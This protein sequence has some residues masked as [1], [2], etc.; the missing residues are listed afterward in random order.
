MRTASRFITIV[1]FVILKWLIPIVLDALFKLEIV[2]LAIKVLHLHKT[3][4]NR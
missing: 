4:K 1:L 3:K 2:P